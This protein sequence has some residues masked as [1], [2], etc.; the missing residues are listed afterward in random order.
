LCDG[1]QINFKEAG[2]VGFH[3][4]NILGFAGLSDLFHGREGQVFQVP[5]SFRLGKINLP[6]SGHGGIAFVV[7]FVVGVKQEVIVKP[8]EEGKVGSRRQGVFINH[9]L[10]FFPVSRKQVEQCFLID[11]AV[12]KAILEHLPDGIGAMEGFAL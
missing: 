4:L 8:L 11:R 10:G 12:N 9:G 6:G 2:Q 3:H 5:G 7:V 1:G